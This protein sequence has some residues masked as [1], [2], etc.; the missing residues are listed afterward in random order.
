MP[1]QIIRNDITKVKA[2][3]IVNTANPEPVFGNGTDKAIY[4][5]AGAEKLLAERKKI[6]RLRVGETAVTPAFDL[7]AKY[8]I[9]TVGPKWQGGNRGETE[10]LAFCYR[11]PLLIAEQ[12]G[13]ESIA[14]PLIAAGVYGFPKEKALSVAFSVISDFLK[15]S[16]MEVTLTVFGEES[17]RLSSAL[18]ENV[19]QYIDEKYVSERELEEYGPGGPQAD[20]RRGRRNLYYDQADMLYGSVM[21]A[22]A[23]VDSEYAEEMPSASDDTEEASIYGREPYDNAYAA[24]SCPAS[25]RRDSAADKTAA[26]APGTLKKGLSKKSISRKSLSK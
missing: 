22:G 7:P 11:K 20:R 19:R 23:P 1:F 6:G 10:D 2:D 15:D 4:L 26:P 13:C 25:A 24:P 17:F 12:L 3:A 16:E 21:E 9:H 18:T 8:I 14:F 5:A